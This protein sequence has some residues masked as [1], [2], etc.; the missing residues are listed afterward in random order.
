M[1]LTDGGLEMAIEVEDSR[2]DRGLSVS[3][4]IWGFVSKDRRSNS[5]IELNFGGGFI[6]EDALLGMATFAGTVKCVW[7]DSERATGCA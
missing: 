1:T 3:T 6:A 5:E 4:F 7:R 2:I